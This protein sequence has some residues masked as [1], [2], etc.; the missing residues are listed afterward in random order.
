MDMEGRQVA[1][2][3]AARLRYP[4]VDGIPVTLVEEAQSY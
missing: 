3:R 2:L 4:I 1:D